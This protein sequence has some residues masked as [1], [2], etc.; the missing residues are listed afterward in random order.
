M[1]VTITISAY[2]KSYYVL[3]TLH[4]FFHFHLLTTTLIIIPILQKK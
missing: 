2:N 4:I 3:N 1:T